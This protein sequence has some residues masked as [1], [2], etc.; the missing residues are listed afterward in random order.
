MSA[1]THLYEHR[2]SSRIQRNLPETH[3]KVRYTL[4]GTTIIIII[5]MH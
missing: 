2:E 5:I 1:V 3:K 4:I